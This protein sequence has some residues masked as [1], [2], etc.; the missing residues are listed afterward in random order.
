MDVPIFGDQPNKR[1][2]E[3]NLGGQHTATSH[4]AILHEAKLRRMQR[5]DEKRRQDAAIRIQSSWRGYSALLAARK[6]LR[7][8]FEQDI[9]S[10]TALRCL[11]LMGQDEDAL[12]RWSTVV[13]SSRKGAYHHTLHILFTH[14]RA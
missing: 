12:G 3:I 1:R 5:N 7:T 10:L 2:R 9:T 14:T 13:L 4:S 8:T 11:V 6:R